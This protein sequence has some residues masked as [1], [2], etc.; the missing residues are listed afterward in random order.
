MISRCEERKTFEKR[1]LA[2]PLAGCNDEIGRF[3]GVRDIL[4]DNNDDTCA[5][6][7]EDVLVNIVL[8]SIILPHKKPVP[9]SVVALADRTS[10][11]AK[12]GP[13]GVIEDGVLHQ[14]SIT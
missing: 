3:S 5:D 14:L 6:G 7:I 8:S 12:Q 9:M 1:R 13:K 11:V 10:V 4:P 2:L